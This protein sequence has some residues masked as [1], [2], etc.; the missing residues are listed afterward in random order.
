M[1]EIESIDLLFELMK[2]R[3]WYFINEVPIFSRSSAN[4]YKKRL[5]ENKLTNNSAE[6]ILKKLGWTKKEFWFNEN[7]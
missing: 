3:K 1:K 5:Y 6:S 7:N 4:T 2:N